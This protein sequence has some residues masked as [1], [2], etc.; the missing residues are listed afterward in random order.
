[1]EI[2]S[3]LLALCEGNSPDPGEFPSQRPV[4]RTFDVSLICIWTN[5]RVNNRDAGDLRRHRA[6]H[7][8]IVMQMQSEDINWKYHLMDL[9]NH[10]TMEQLVIY[11]AVAWCN[12]VYFYIDP[13]DVFRSEIWIGNI[14]TMS[15]NIS[16]FSNNIKLSYIAAG[17]VWHHPSVVIFWGNSFGAWS[18]IWCVHYMSIVK[19]T[20]QNIL[21]KCELA[22]VTI[23]F[24]YHCVNEDF[25]HEQ[26]I[27][28]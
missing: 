5:G 2:F 12:A 8:V 23:L 9:S 3:A 13:R 10:Q 21:V 15:G 24:K 18:R 7:D 27:T 11:S 16:S 28:K 19:W 20:L 26:T 17:K 6:H 4:T 14:P 25:H 1:M 22:A